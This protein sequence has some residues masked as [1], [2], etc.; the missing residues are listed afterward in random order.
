MQIAHAHR[1]WGY[2]FIWAYLGKNKYL[3]SL[4]VVII[5]SLHYQNWG[6][7]FR[8]QPNN[9]LFRYLFSPIYSTA[10]PYCDWLQTKPTYFSCL[11]SPGLAEGGSGDWGAWRGHG[12]QADVSCRGPS[13]LGWDHAAALGGLFSIGA[14]IRG[15]DAPGAQ[16]A[17]RGSQAIF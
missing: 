14:I 7:K 4:A 13:W 16:G 15:G 9:F 3:K 2:S 12:E 1:F 8:E 6:I 11:G 5:F 17:D 10:S